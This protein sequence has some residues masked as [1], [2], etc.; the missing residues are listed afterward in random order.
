MAFPWLSETGFEDGTRGHFDAETDTEN[1]LDFPHYSE[2]ARVGGPEMPWRGAYCMRVNLANDGS[3]A[4]AYVQET[5]SWDLAATGVIFLRLMFYVSRDLVMGNTDEFA[6]FQLWSSTNTVEG[7]AYINF[8]TANGL[9]LGIGEASATSFTPL[10]QG[11]WHCLELGYVID[12]GAGN[13]GTLD[14]WLDGA[15]LTQVTGL[16][17]GAITS[18]VLGVLGQDATTTRGTILFDDIVADDARIYPPS[19]RFPDQLI[20]TTSGH[21]FVGGGELAQ[22]E[23]YSGGATDNVLAVYDTD[24]GATNDASNSKLE[25]KNTANNERVPGDDPVRVHRGA[26]VALSGT[27]PRALAKIGWANSYSAGAMRQ[28][29]L[30]RTPNPTG[31]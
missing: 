12:S 25:L 6:L 15:A 28:Q 21:V 20:L 16:D 31:A 13:D 11:V 29:G 30:R 24:R 22:V 8:T 14:A 7:G 27:N 17:Q 1:R 10:T 2:L 5:G 18:G 23:L 19:E 4:D 9:R 26:Y 3:P